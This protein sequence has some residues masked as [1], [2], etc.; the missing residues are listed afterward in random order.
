M[1]VNFNGHTVYATAE[2]GKGFAIETVN[3]RH[4]TYT[5]YDTIAEAYAMGG[6]QATYVVLG[7]AD[8]STITLG[9][10]NLGFFGH[11]WEGD[12]GIVGSIVNEPALKN[13]E[14]T[15]KWG[16]SGMNFEFVAWTDKPTPLMPGQGSK[17]YETRE[18]AEAAAAETEV[19]PAEGFGLTGDALARWQGFFVNQVYLGGDGKFRIMPELNADGSNALAQAE[20]KLTR[21]IDVSTIAAATGAIEEMVLEGAEPGFYYTLFK[22]TDVTVVLEQE[23]HD[24][25]NC[26]CKALSDG[27]VTFT[28]VT[29]PSAAVGFFAVRAFV[30]ESFTNP[31]GG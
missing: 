27:K 28:N 18:E 10:G 11:F 29:K 1:C 22:S 4:R 21:A 14:K 31:F 3:S 20:A 7:T 12:G 19:L 15:E 24:P 13:A 17:A 16:A 8:A 2:R 23:N 5:P 30:K 26:D 6:S 25:D 9:P